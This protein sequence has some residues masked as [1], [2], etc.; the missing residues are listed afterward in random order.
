M[1]KA[2]EVDI[3]VT[4]AGELPVAELG[5]TLPHEH[6]IHRIS[7]HSGKPDNT[8]V[9]INVVAEELACFRA[10]G[11]TTVCDL[12][13]PGIGRDP[14]ALRELARRSGVTIISGMGIYQLEAWP[15]G[16]AAM[17]ETDLADFLVRQALGGNTGIAAGIIGEVASHNEDHCDWRKYEL[18]DNEQMLFHAVANAQKRTGLTVSTHASLGRAGV[19]Q[20][21]TLLAGGADPQRIVIGHCATQGHSDMAVDLDYY[22]TL[23]AEGVFLAFDQFGWE[24]LLSDGERRRRVATLVD[25]GF[26]DR[27]LLSTDT[28]RLSHLH[29]YG[30]RGF[31]FLFTHVLPGLREFGVRDEHLHQMTV[32]NPARILTQLPSCA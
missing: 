4:V 23:L 16:L 22:H 31:D 19:A 13:T 11:G 21:R 30:G 10:A 24:D 2:K 32:T 26:A 28:C 6:L 14:S 7:I 20:V 8:C 29:R 9:D 1:H 17:S 25:E 15:A 3:A 27:I 12:T 18:L 5:V